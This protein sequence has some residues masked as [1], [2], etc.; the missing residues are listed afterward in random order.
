MNCEMK[1]L[2]SEYVD[3]TLTP[4]QRR[5]VQA[6]LE[7]CAS[8]AG[9]A[10]DFQAMSHLLQGLPTAQTSPEFDSRLTARLART[11]RPS[12]L[13]S[14]LRRAGSTLWPSSSALRP[15]LALGAALLVMVGVMFHPQPAGPIVPPPIPEAAGFDKPLVTQCV[16]QHR[17]DI[18]VQPLSDI[19]AQNLATQLDASGSLTSDAAMGEDNL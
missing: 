18:A 13:T 5:R 16:E 2:I 3:G 17:N 4:N 1:S 14:W 19:A 11:R 9:L 10:E 12:P 8:C 6:H 15:A 7:Q